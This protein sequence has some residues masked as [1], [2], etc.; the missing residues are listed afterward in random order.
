MG[1]SIRGSCIFNLRMKVLALITPHK[2]L[3]QPSSL[4]LAAAHLNTHT[5]SMDQL[6]KLVG[7]SELNT[8]QCSTFTVVLVVLVD[9]FASSSHR[10]GDRF[11][12]QRTSGW[13]G[14]NWHGLLTTSPQSTEHF[15]PSTWAL[16]LLGMQVRS[17]ALLSHHR[18]NGSYYT[19]IS[20]APVTI[21][22]T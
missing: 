8:S 18:F 17:S 21:A 14:P 5:K 15:P 9:V 3:L 6:I 10:V 7:A 1:L 4:L 20:V 11:L 2:A 13:A 22:T 16:P 12:S 19:P